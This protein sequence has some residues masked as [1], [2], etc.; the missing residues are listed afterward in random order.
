MWDWLCTDLGALA[1]LG[2]LVGLVTAFAWHGQRPT[3][4]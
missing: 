2:G 3:G 1:V 4:R